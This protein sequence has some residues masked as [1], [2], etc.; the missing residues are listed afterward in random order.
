MIPDKQKGIARE[1]DTEMVF[2]RAVFLAAAIIIAIALSI[3]GATQIEAQR[4]PDRARQGPT[5]EMIKACKAKQEGDI[6]SAKGRNGNE[7]TGTCFAPPN[8][9]L[10]CRP[11]NRNAEGRVNQGQVNP[12]TPIISTQA[13]TFAVLCHEETD[14]LNEQL[15]L[16]SEAKWLCSNGQ[17]LLVANGVPDHQ[18]GAFPNA[19][20]LNEISAQTVNFVTTLSPIAHSGSGI[21]V[22]ESAYALNGIKFDPVT[23]GRCP[24]DAM[25]LSDCDLGQGT[26]QWTIEALGQSSFDFGNDANHANVQPNGS[27]HYRGIPEAMLTEET[28]AGKSMQLI[29]WAADG[30]PIYARYGHD[31]VKFLNSPLRAMKSSYQ[32]KMIADDGRPNIDTFPMGVFT[33]DYEYVEGLGDLDECNGRFGPTQEFPEGIYHYYATDSFP[34]FQRCVKGSTNSKPT[35]QRARGQRGNGNRRGNGERRG[36]GGRGGNGGGNGGGGQR[37]R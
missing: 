14:V 2:P 4:N 21:Q 3:F 9:S 13:Q 20:N 16:K 33:Q 31:Q 26:G 22:K 17:R 37:P 8:R 19:N 28:R 1:G 36:R 32:L 23:A 12:G 6:C 18:T 15:G 34:F 7:I 11:A 10:A 35:A 30:F 25:K 5:K 27:Y 29:G 24:S